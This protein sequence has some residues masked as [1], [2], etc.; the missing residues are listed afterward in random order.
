MLGEEEV[1]ILDVL[2]IGPHDCE[3]PQEIEISK[4]KAKWERGRKTGVERCVS[5]GFGM[6]WT[7]RTSAAG[8]QAKLA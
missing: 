8:I 7:S 5:M 4:R 3:G 6:L 1:R 2:R